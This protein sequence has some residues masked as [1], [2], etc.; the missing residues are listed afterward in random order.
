MVSAYPDGTQLPNT[1][2]SVRSS[3]MN[4]SI[5]RSFEA[6]EPILALVFTWLSWYASGRFEE[7]AEQESE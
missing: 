6:L 7:D 2:S 3:P 5:Q 1:T 4:S